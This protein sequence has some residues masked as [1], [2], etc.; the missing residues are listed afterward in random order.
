MAHQVQK[1]KLHHIDR[2]KRNETY[3]I[4]TGRNTCRKMDVKTYEWTKGRDK[5][6][7]A[8]SETEGKVKESKHRDQTKML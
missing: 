1:R 2:Q 8:Q 6:N 4:E 3:W 5:Q 7:H